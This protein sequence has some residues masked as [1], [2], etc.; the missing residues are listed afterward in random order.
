M[1][2]NELEMGILKY[3]DM[4]IAPKMNN[5]SKFMLYTTSFLVA[6]KLE[7]I[8]GNNIAM[9]QQLELIDND[10]NIDL[11]NVYKACKNAMAKTGNVEFKGIVFNEN[12]VDMLYNYIKGGN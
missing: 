10:G 4:E 11:D 3:I 1:K 9:L 7:K 5:L 6:P 2:L 8:V 12:D